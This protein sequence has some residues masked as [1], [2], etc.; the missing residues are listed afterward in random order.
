LPELRDRFTAR[1]EVVR[2]LNDRN[3]PDLPF[4]HLSGDGI[5]QA[6]EPDGTT[7]LRHELRAADLGRVFARFTGGFERVAAVPAA[8]SQLREAVVARYFPWTGS[9][10]LDATPRTAPLSEPK[11]AEDAPEYGR[12]AAFRKTFLSLYDHQC[13]ACGLRIL[14]PLGHH[15]SFIDAAHLLPWGE[16]RNDHPTNG[17]A[18]CKNHHWAMDH[19]VIAPSPDHTWHVSRLLVA[20]RSSGETQLRQ[21]AG[22]P[23]LLPRD[24]AFHPDPNGLAWRWERLLGA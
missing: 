23:V 19:G 6:F 16:Y 5:W 17:L 1:F 12:S 8:R 7:P 3:S 24:P 10:L 15:V 21:L 18:L 11:V 2:K 9:A 22:Q 14:L 4:R 20:H 13:A